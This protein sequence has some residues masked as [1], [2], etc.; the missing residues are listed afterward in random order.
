MLNPRCA[1]TCLFA[2]LCSFCTLSAAGPDSLAHRS[3]ADSLRSVQADQVVVTGTRNNVRLKDSP[4]RV[5]IIGEEQIRAT[6]MVNMA[7][8]LKEQN[9]LLMQGNVRTGVQMNG[10]GP[11]YTLILIDGQPVIGRVA[12][13]IDLTRLS[14]GNIERVE[15]VKGPLSSMYGSEALAGVI[16]IITK[17]PDD[18][19]T[20]SVHTQYVSK[21]P[22]E[23]RLEGGWGSPN[24]EIGGF[25][26]VRKSAEFQTVMDTLTIPYAGFSDATAQLKMQHKIS[27]NWLVKGWGR[28]FTS[29]S[30]GDFIESVQGQISKNSGSV[31]QSDLSTTVG[32]EYT[33]NAARLQLTA[34]AS[35][36]EELYNF[37][38]D[39][40]AAGKTDNMTRRIARLYAQYDLI[41]GEADRLTAG[42]EFIYDDISGTRYIPDTATNTNPLMYRTWVGFAQWEGLPTDWISYVLSARFDGNSVYGAALS[43]RFSMLWKP[44]SHFRFTGSVGT[45]FK[46]PDFRQLFVSFS[47][48]LPGAGYDLIGAELLGVELQPERSIS[49][50]LGIRYD[51]GI[52]ELS[53]LAVLAYNADVRLFRN[54]LENLIEYYL[55]GIVD[56]RS[57]YSYRNLSKVTTQGI[58][59][60]IH[61][62]LSNL[63]L[64]TITLSTGYQFLDAYDDE[65]VNAIKNGT[66][67]T[68][69]HKL[70]LNEYGG[71]WNR[72]KHSGSVRLQYDSPGKLWSANI[73]A[74]FVGGYGDESLDK[75]GIVMSNPPRKVLDRPD[76]YVKGYTVLNAAVTHTVLLGQTRLMLGAGIN[77][78]LNVLN[79]MLIPGLVGTQFYVQASLHL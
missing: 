64:G 42:G 57:V 54:D 12:G 49:Y 67:G 73:R 40:G 7:D 75:N 62:A 53:D 3:L 39:Q 34:Y 15:V 66:A 48:R 17:R 31:E 76:E 37:D 43:P 41:M 44:H 77:N 68:I 11:D 33:R 59:A 10:L 14:V 25:V 32:V 26:N 71:L 30:E 1:A 63:E 28:Y 5:E 27:R 70:T 69:T 2:L 6:A 51:N 22:A 23:V 8:L 60:N 20:G 21:G 74:Q 16:N 50:D 36:Y 35:D 38:V 18:G 9:G 61:L 24:T 65:V 4:V 46:A 72:S 13:I 56:E 45:G 29:A 78:A 55:Y 47:N 79:P 52:Y 58:E 19:F